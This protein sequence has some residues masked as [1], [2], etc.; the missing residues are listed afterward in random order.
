MQ[1]ASGGGS[2]IKKLLPRQVDSNTPTQT[3]PA[4]AFDLPTR[5]RS[6]LIP[7]NTIPNHWGCR[8]HFP[9]RLK[10]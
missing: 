4:A 2:A 10:A 3:L 6:F 8:N 7:V 9:C 1:S 5:G